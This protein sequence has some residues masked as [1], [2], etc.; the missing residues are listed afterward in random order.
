[1]SFWKILLLIAA[2]MLALIVV[3]IVGVACVIAGREYRRELHREDEDGR[4]GTDAG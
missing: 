3:I 4:D 2:I 1:M